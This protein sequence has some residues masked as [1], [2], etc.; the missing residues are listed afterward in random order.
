MIQI[1]VDR[2][3]QTYKGGVTNDLGEWTCTPKP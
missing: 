3:S 2:A 1:K